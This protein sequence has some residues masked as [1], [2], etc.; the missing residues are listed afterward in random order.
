MSPDRA[1]K[2]RGFTLIELLVVIA[3][4]GVLIALLMPA[5]QTA[6]EAA[7]RAQ[8]SNNLRQLGLAFHHYHA[9]KNV[10]PVG[11]YGGSLPTVAAGNTAAAQAK[12]IGSWGQ[13]LLPFMDE[14]VLYNSINQGLWYV[15]P[16]NST[17]GQTVL[18]VFLCPSNQVTSL[19][20]PNGDNSSAL[21]QYA[22]SDYSGNYGERAL[23]CL[24]VGSCPNN[25]GNTAE[26]AR[27]VLLTVSDPINSAATILD[28]LSCT[29][30][31]GE[32]HVAIFGYWISHKNF[33]DQSAPIS[34]VNGTVPG[35]F[36]QSCQVLNTSPL[37]G[38]IACDL[39]QEFASYHMD[40]A[41]FLFADSSVRF[42]KS[43]TSPSVLAAI[44]SRQG[45][46]VVSA[47]DY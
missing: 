26:G 11:G 45:G 46:E 3:I 27:G 44:L 22:R 9:L 20:R 13:S 37:L 25:Y 2:R 40:G 1:I 41:N 18:S 31:V 32:A 5:V 15:Q 38:K 14:A 30:M 39:T 34:A 21:P 6:R 12:R 17:A 23:R 36:W 29:I 24:Q 7:R 35:T 43:S 28:G 33:L 19:F 16:E 47:S 42:V 10:F 4:I 8:C